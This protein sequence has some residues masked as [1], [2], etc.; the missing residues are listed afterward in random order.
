MHVRDLLILISAC[1][2]KNSLVFG[3]FFH[4]TWKTDVN[5]ATL[6]GNQKCCASVRSGS[7]KGNKLINSF[8]RKMAKV[9]SAREARCC[10]VQITNR[11]ASSHS[12]LDYSSNFS[13]ISHSSFKT[14][15]RSRIQT[16]ISILNILLL[17]NRFIQYVLPFL[18]FFLVLFNIYGLLL[19]IIRCKHW[20]R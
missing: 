20:T 14:H 9:G 13:S 1:C 2:E 3:A 8:G 15:G 16:N 19:I 11:P 7:S 10:Q 18:L 12:H 5:S 6:H 17:D 4:S